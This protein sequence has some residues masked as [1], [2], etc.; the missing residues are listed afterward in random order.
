MDVLQIGVSSWIIQDGNYDDFE[1]GKSYKFALEFC[2]EDTSRSDDGIDD[3]PIL[4]HEAG[5]MFRVRGK[6]IYATESSWVVDFGVP[7]FSEEQPPMWAMAGILVRGRVYIGIDPYSY[8]EYLKDEPGM[9]NLFRHWLVR[10]ILLETTPWQE[11]IDSSG[12]KLITRADVPPSFVDV[13]RTNA[14]KDD[15]GSAHYILECEPSSAV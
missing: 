8:L 4:H 6:V 3:N 12:R 13:P 7:A 15:A 11:T 14:W 10:R 2:P 5:A 1:V 9:P